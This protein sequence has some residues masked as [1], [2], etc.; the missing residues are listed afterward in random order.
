LPDKNVFEIQQGVAIGIWSKVRAGGTTSAYRADLLGT[1]EE[2]YAFLLEHSWSDTGWIE[3]TSTAPHYLFA[4]TD[5]DLMAEYSAFVPLP[6]AMP[7]HSNGIVTARDHLCISWTASEVWSKVSD[8]VGLD[9][10]VARDKYALGDDALDWQVALAQDDLR[11]DGPKKASVIP[12]LYRPYDVRA[13]Y[14]TGHSRGFL[15][16]PRGEVMRNMLLGDNVGLITSRLTKG[17]KFAHVQATRHATEAIVMS[18]KTSNNGFLFPLFVT[19]TDNRS[20]LTNDRELTPNFSNTFLNRLAESLG[21]AMD[22]NRGLPSNIE[23]I[24]V[25]GF[26]YAALHSPTYRER[27]SHFLTLDFPRVPLNASSDLFRGLSD[28]GQ[29]LISLSL[30][31]AATQRGISARFAETW[32]YEITSSLEV[33]VALSFEGP[34]KPTVGKVAWSN[35]NVWLDS[36]NGKEGSARFH[37]VTEAVW[38]FHV[39]GYQVCLKWLKDRRGRTL[40]GADLAMYYK[41]IIATHETI[42]IMGKI[43][44]MIDNHGG[45]PR[46]FATATVE[47]SD[48]HRY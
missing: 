19:D 11:R 28:L 27:Y 43:D 33:P 18:P 26:I 15:C 2:K 30:A 48:H 47:I 12:I 13:T 1:R 8:L 21:L 39:G 24:D 42:R 34:E 46:A 10:E 38:T 37:P 22:R 17:E 29:Q 14:F 7:V 45:W 44:A 35:G 5:A 40:S 6:E 25:L 20:L 23:A 9:P 32:R 41:L 36:P 3:F 31:E 4:P 16:R